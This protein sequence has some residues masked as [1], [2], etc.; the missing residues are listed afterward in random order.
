MK[1]N[2]LNISQSNYGEYEEKLNILSK[3]SF[4]T[5][6]KELEKI[7]IKRNLAGMV[8]YECLCFI[9]N[10]LLAFD[11]IEFNDSISSSM[12]IVNWEQL[13]LKSNLNLTEREFYK[14]VYN[15]MINGISNIID[16]DIMYNTSNRFLLNLRDFFCLINII[17]KE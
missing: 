4:D 8:N 9:K 17:D 3:V 7:S 14:W 2:I 15:G 11:K 10:T 12:I 1:E 6:I 13:R 5:F 16:E